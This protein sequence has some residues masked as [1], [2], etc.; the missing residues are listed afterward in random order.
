M[1]PRTIFCVSTISFAFFKL[2]GKMTFTSDKLI[3]RKIIKGLKYEQK[4]EQNLTND[5][6]L[7]IIRG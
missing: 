7:G 2:N 6:F 3:S 5:F 4:D 1:I